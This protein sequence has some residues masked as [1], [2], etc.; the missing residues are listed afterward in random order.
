LHHPG[1]GRAP[2]QDFALR[3]AENAFFDTGVVDAEPLSH[4]LV[5]PGI[6]RPGMG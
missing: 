4:G 1:I 5:S 2:A 6:E 3:F